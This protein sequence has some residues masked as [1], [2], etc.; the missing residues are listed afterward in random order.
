M[1]VQGCTL[2][3][4]SACTRLHFTL[5]QCLY[6]GALYLTSVPV[7]G[8][9]LPLP[10][11]YLQLKNH[12]SMSGSGNRL[13]SLFQNVR[14]NSEAHQAYYSMGTGYIPPETERPGS[15][16]DGSSP[17]D[18]DKDWVELY[19]HSV[20]SRRSGNKHNFT[21]DIFRTKSQ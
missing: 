9:T 13:I 4:L 16:F 15:E 19:L 5:P 7:Q 11:L 14:T 20:I 3:Y 1:P 8:C 21:F 17:S 12:G 6:K 2:P 10:L 18:K